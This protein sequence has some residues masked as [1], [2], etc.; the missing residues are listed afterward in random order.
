M[1]TIRKQQL[2]AFEQVAHDDYWEAM[3]IQVCRQ[4]RMD[5][6]DARGLVRRVM[7]KAEAFGIVRRRDCQNLVDLTLELGADFE[8]HPDRAAVRE[9]LEH[10]SL[11][12]FAK[13][14]LVDQALTERG[15]AHAG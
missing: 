15:A 9:A 6:D 2:Q 14:M 8:R 12:G 7:A 13:M 1:V 3:V 4:A 11:P 10:P 5:E